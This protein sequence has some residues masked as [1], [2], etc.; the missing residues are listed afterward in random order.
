MTEAGPVERLPIDSWP[1]RGPSVS[2]SLILDL[3]RF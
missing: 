2:V 1:D 3:D